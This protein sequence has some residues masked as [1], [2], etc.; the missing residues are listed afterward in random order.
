[1]KVKDLVFG[2][3]YENVTAVKDFGTEYE[4]TLNGNRKI[5]GKKKDFKILEGTAI[6]IGN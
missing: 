4:I 6:K 1:M 2:K 5:A 3:V